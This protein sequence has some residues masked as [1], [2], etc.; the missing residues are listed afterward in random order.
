MIRSIRFND[1]DIPVVDSKL[2]THDHIGTFKARW[3]INRMNYIIDPGLY[4]LGRPT[5]TSDIFVT[6][7][8]KL[9]FDKLRSALPGINA[10][11]LVLNTNGINVWCAAGKRTFCT[12]ELVNKI[13]SSRL[14]E[15]VNHRRLIVPQLGAPGIA[16]HEVKKQTGFKVTYGPIKS[17][18]IPAFIKSGYQATPSMR[19]KDFPLSE[20]LVLIPMELIPA[21]KHMAIILPVMFIIGGFFGSESFL[22]NAITN[23]L[24]SLIMII[25]GLTAGTIITPLALPWLPGKAF[26]FKAMT[27]GLMTS[28]FL[29]AIL[30]LYSSNTLPLSQVLSMCL[31]C[32]GLSSFLGMNFTGGSTYTSLSGVRKEMKIAVPLQITAVIAGLLTWMVSLYMI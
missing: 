20:R 4:A 27:A 24:F 5:D 12:A 26:S 18:D 19:K 21:L 17:A 10:W 2:S 30:M 9:S 1:Q 29:I 23:S 8:Y 6:A 7:N 22:E 16:A 3:G 32:S 14:S 28:L 25:G 15:L 13:K 11:I 31:L